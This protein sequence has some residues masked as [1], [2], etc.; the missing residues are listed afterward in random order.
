MA[1]LTVRL[2]DSLHHQLAEQARS[3]GV[4]LN[5]Y[6]VFSLTR[7]GTATQLGAQRDQFEALLA[8]TTSEDAEASFQALLK[9]R[10]PAVSTSKAE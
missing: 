8:T 4:S 3:E 1:R 10:S 6:I 5:Q 9:T 7:A 2:P